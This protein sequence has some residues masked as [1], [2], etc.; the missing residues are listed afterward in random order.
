MKIPVKLKLSR[1]CALTEGIKPF[2]K[3]TAAQKKSVA[4]CVDKKMGLSGS[5]KAK[6]ATR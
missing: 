5:K 1:E 3:W 4:A 2:K 6:K